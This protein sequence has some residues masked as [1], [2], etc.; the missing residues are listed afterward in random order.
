MIILCNQDP[1]KRKDAAQK[2][3]KVMFSFFVALMVRL[4][5]IDFKVKGQQFV[6][7]ASGKI[8]I[9]N[10]PSL[11]DVVLI[12]ASI[13]KATCIVKK[14]VYQNPFMS[15]VVKTAGYIVNSNPEVL[16][17]QCERVLASGET[18]VIFPE[19]TRTVPGQAISFQRG[20]ANIALQSGADILPV[21]VTCKP[22]TLT[23]S[24][25]WYQ[26]PD[27]K[28][29]FEISFQPP[30]RIDTMADCAE[31]S[32][33]RSRKLTRDLEGYFLEMLQRE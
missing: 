9:A 28:P 3:I 7:Q 2:L 19:G 27:C 21:K 1:D 20:A 5:I 10:H 29:K 22:N 23:K 12:V 24:E 26:V 18:L 4:G 8:I 32:S 15:I 11:I 6:D 17:T 31:R 25:R 30:L 16:L 14:G 33:L 13:P